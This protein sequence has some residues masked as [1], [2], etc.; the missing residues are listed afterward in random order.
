MATADRTVARYRAL[1]SLLTTTTATYARPVGV[2]RVTGNDRQTYLHSLLSQHLEDA[3]PGTVADFLYLDAKGS[4]L[5]EGRAIVRAGDVL[6]VTPAV[7]TASLADALGRFTFLLDATAEDVSDGWRMVSVRGSDTDGLPGAR[8]QRMTAAPHGDGIVV[9][10]R[11]G[12]VDYLGSVAWVTERVAEL[13]LPEADPH[14]WELWRIRAAVPAWGHEIAAGR[15]TQELGLLPTHVHLRKGCYPGQE[16]IAKTWN[17]G[18]PRRA[19]WV[20]EFDA[21]VPADVEVRV[22][23]RTGVITSAAP[24]GART[25]ALALLPLERD[26]SLADRTL[27]ADGVPGRALQRVGDDLPQP[28]A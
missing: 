7:V 8:S 5:A 27:D 28:G 23:D 12:G 6:L 20:A 1:M 26:G 15:R 2:I 17:L 13:R 19:L 4:A 22:G 24:D 11:S 10:D 16:S 3:R 14:D 9:R 18:R 21:A 25:V